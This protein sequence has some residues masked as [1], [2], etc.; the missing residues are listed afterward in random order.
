MLICIDNVLTPAEVH[1]FR[2]QLEAAEW[3]EGSKSAGT[4][5][6][7]RK[8][9]LQLAESSPLAISLGNEILRRL[10]NQPQFISAALPSKIYPPRFNQY[11]KGDTYGTH[12]DSA[13]MRIPGTNVTLRSDV[14]AT[15]FISDPESYDGGELEIEGATGAQAVKLEAGHLVIYPSSSLHRVTEVTRGTRYASFFWIESLVQNDVAR[16][17]LFDLDQAI[18]R[19]TARL[20]PQ[21]GDLLGL[22]NVYHNMLRHWAHT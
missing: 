9:N 6:R 22:T 3:E 15:L 2:R 18:Q 1:D 12:V 5:A 8:R 21:D 10:G 13:V 17:S 20:G 19:L 16:A 11:A 7:S 4:L 14:S